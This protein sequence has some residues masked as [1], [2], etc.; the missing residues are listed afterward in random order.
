MIATLALVLLAAGGPPS[1]L[2][3]ARPDLPPHLRPPAEVLGDY[4]KAVGGPA[5]WKRHKNVHMKR[6]V[7]VKGM[8]ISG[9]EDRYATDTDRSLSVTALGAM[10]S[11]RQGSDGKVAWSEDPINGLRI[12]EGA[13]AEEAKIDASWNAELQLTKLYQKV[14]AVQPPEPPPA[15]KKYECLE[16]VPK[17]A[18]P[19]VA[20]FDAQTH[21]RTIQKGTHSTAQGDVPYKVVFSDWRQVDGMTMPY[22]E[23][24]IA[25]PVT[26]I[27][28][29]T[30]L[31]FDEKLDPK[32]FA[33]PKVAKPT[34][35]GKAAKAA[36]DEPVQLQQN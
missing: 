22:E 6:K 11:F 29:V 17:L 32:M 34:K 19:A 24:M 20:C 8:Q 18:K 31:K 21:L 14:H 30:E 33:L 12:L 27:G 1:S 2:T 3:G 15:G 13:E 4:V 16:L 25:G 7:E 36:S 28:Q 5:A 23:E 35:P 26:I 10:G 9:T